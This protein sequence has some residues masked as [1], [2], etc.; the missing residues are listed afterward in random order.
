VDA[1]GYWG[2]AVVNH[3]VLYVEGGGDTHSLRTKCREAFSSFL[4]KA[5]LQGMKPRIVACGSRNEA[6]ADYAFAL[7]QKERAMLLVD[8]EAPVTTP[9]EG[10]EGYKK[11]EPHTWKPWYHLQVVDHGDDLDCHFMVECMETWF[12]A[13]TVAL[14]DYFKDG[15]HTNALPKRNDIESIPKDKVLSALKTAS[16]N[17]TK[18]PYDKGKHSFD[19]LKEIDP[20]LVMQHSPWANRFVCILTETMKQRQ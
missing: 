11:A 17:C 1:W 20:Q 12:L 9:H 10:Y 13:D 16:K 5:G 7:K 15:F 8:S 4:E 2:D 19:L 18:G 6:C 14:Q 3:V